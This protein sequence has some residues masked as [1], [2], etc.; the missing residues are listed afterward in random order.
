MARVC[1]I[2]AHPEKRAIDAAAVRG[3]AIRGI[4]RQYGISADALQRHKDSHLTKGLAKAEAKRA[5]EALDHAALARE[6]VQKARDVMARA[7][8]EAD[9]D[10]TES[11]D[12][13]V[14]KALVH[15]GKMAEFHAKLTGAFAPT[16]V[17][18][19]QPSDGDLDA[20]AAEWLEGRGWK[21]TPP[22]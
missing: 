18:L 16:Q 14:L 9:P 8:A 1:S 22:K 6:V 11:A 17:E 13:R 7:E 4:A 5:S 19:V 12:E 3:A 2:C 20:R 21:L 15:L 10:R